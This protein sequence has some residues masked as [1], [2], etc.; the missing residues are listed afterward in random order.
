[1]AKRSAIVASLLV[2]T[3]EF[4]ED[5]HHYRIMI[6]H[7]I[8]NQRHLLKVYHDSNVGMHQGRE[9]TYGA[10]MEKHG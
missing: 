2:Y 9:A 10:L 1:M 5:P 4:M 3:G 7:D 8:Q 6:P